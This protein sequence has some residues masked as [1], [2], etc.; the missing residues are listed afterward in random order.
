M[1]HNYTIEHTL[2]VLPITNFSMPIAI[3]M[4]DLSSN[5]K[6]LCSG[7]KLSTSG[8]SLWVPSLCFLKHK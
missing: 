2:S 8:S 6:H 7:R 3:A 5:T 4:S 1:K